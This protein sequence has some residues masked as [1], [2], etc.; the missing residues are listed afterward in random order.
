MT[1]WYSWAEKQVIPGL[2]GRLPEHPEEYQAAMLQATA[3]KIALEPNTESPGPCS[4]MW[5]KGMINMMIQTRPEIE[6]EVVVVSIFSSFHF[7]QN[8]D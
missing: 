8:H 2:W 3:A 1:D 7:H 6:S 4:E 5:C